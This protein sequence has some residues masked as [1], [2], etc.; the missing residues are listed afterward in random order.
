MF[1]NSIWPAKPVTKAIPISQTDSVSGIRL[2]AQADFFR[3]DDRPEI[4][5][6]TAEATAAPEPSHGMAPAAQ[7]GGGQDAVPSIIE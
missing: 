5:C 6:A 2:P 4:R 7:S 3:F 1:A